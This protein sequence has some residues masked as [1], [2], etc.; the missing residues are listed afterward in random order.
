M[1]RD[2]GNGLEVILLDPAVLVFGDTAKGIHPFPKANDAPVGSD[3]AH[4]ASGVENSPVRISEKTGEGLCG[5]QRQGGEENQQGSGFLA[6][7]WPDQISH[8]CLTLRNS[9]TIPEMDFPHSA[10]QIVAPP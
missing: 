3:P 1:R 4:C 10:C 6:N 8:Y 2:D 5:R 7:F 9:S